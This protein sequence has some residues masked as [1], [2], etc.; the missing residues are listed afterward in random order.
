MRLWSAPL[1]NKCATRRSYPRWHASSRGVFAY[2]SMHSSAN[3]CF[4]SIR[5][6]LYKSFRLTASS[7]WLSMSVRRQSWS[8]FLEFIFF[9]SFAW[10]VVLV[11]AFSYAQVIAEMMRNSWYCRARFNRLLVGRWRERCTSTVTDSDLSPNNTDEECHYA[12]GVINKFETKHKN[13][14]CDECVCL[15]KFT[16]CSKVTLTLARFHDMRYTKWTIRMSLF[17]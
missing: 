8:I 17:R 12:I 13:Y 1:F 14:V 6:R 2:S 16:C 5:C 10:A 11:V 3:G 7:T 4:S 15:K 9:L